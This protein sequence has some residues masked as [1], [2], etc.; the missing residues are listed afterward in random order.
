MAGFLFVTAS[1]AVVL[2]LV[3]LVAGSIPRTTGGQQGPRPGGPA[4][5]HGSTSIGKASA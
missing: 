5:E 2:G 1:V 4:R 3:G